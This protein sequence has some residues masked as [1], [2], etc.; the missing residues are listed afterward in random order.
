MSFGVSFFRAVDEEEARERLIPVSKGTGTS[1]SHEESNMPL[2]RRASK[3]CN[4]EM[5]RNFDVGGGKIWMI[6][7]DGPCFFDEDCSSGWKYEFH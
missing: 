5:R 4:Y 6:E 1:A 7:E 3:I 2:R